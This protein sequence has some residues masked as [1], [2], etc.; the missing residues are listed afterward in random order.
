MT[1]VL[2]ANNI[3]L[4]GIVRPGDQVIW[5]QGTGEP[6]TLVEALLRQR[7]E[8]GPI[9]VFLAS[10]FSTTLQGEH[11]DHISFTGFG[12]VGTA[13]RLTKA[14]VLGVVP[15]HVSQIGAYIRG[16]EIPAD[17]AFIQASRGP[18][19][20]LSY[21]V[22]HDYVA[23]LVGKAR[24]VVV[25]VNDQVPFTYGA[26]TIPADKV[27]YIVETS[28][29]VIEVASATPGETDRAIAGHIAPFIG[30][31]SVL[32][33]GIGAV[34][35]AVMSMLTDRRDLGVHSGSIGDGLVDLVEA[36]VV[37]NARKPI[38]RGISIIGGLIG[39][40]RLYQ[41]AH[42]N[43]AIGMRP[44]SYTHGAATLASLPKLVTINS[45]MEVDLSGQVNAEQAG[46]DY[47][48]GIGGQPFYVRA[49]HLSEGGH[50][51]IALPA[52]AKG[53]SVSKICFALSGPVTTQRS[54]VDVIVTE[55]GAAQ[56]RGQPI[57][58]RVRRLIAIAHPTFREQLERDA[59]AMLKRGY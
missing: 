29:P 42:L 13:R 21:G 32:Q 20:E 35:D 2:D 27:D 10:M 37:T 39:T 55:F 28:R 56:L 57:P 26:T 18:N 8:L 46:D 5:G 22:I 34:P 50:S 12:A 41:Y 49:G 44:S 47:I 36:G 9:K 1:K 14:G 59:H 17:V 51:I 15:C 48:G 11:A 30:D 33:I 3:D 7:A 52:T 25:E 58:E 23:D 31:G 54:D 24:T 45:A 53:G 38:D 4:K 16:G 40:K 6:A 43:K 19:G